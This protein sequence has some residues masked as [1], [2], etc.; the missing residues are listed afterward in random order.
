M[1]LT[2]AIRRRHMVRSFAPDP[3]EP[4]LVDR[5]VEAALRAPSAG[6]TRGVAWLLLEGSET[7]TYWEL[8]TDASWRAAH[9]RYPRMSEA[10]VIALSLCSPA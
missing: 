6:N 8:T 1:E 5:L 2:E 10:P 7:A 4:G 3:I 9:L